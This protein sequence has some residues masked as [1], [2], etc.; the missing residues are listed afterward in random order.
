M[1]HGPL[2]G[3]M[4]WVV[5]ASATASATAGPGRVHADQPAPVARG[6]QYLDCPSSR[7]VDPVTLYVATNGLDTNDGRTPNTPLAT[8]AGAQERIGQLDA[9]PLD[10]DYLVYVRGG[11]YREQTVNWTVTSPNHRVHIASYP[12]ENPVFNGASGKNGSAQS[13]LFNLRVNDGSATNLTVRGLTITNYVHRAIRLY[14]GKGRTGIKCNI[15][16]ENRFVDI[17]GRYGRCCTSRDAAGRCIDDKSPKSEAFLDTPECRQFGARG[18]PCDCTGFGAVTAVGSSKNVFLRNTFIN[19]VNRAGALAGLVHAFYMA[20]GSTQN[21]IEGNYVRNCSGVPFK[22]RDGSND[23]TIRGNY[24]EHAGS[25]AFFL[26][27]RG[28]GEALS[29]GNLLSG[30]IVTFGYPP[31]SGIPLTGGDCAPGDT[32]CFRLDSHQNAARFYQ[33]TQPKE[34]IVTAMTSADVTGDGEPET[35]VALYYPALRFTKVVYSDAASPAE[36]TNVAYTSDFW[37]VEHIVAAD[38][39]GRGM[40]LVT[41]LY[42]ADNGRTQVYHGAYSNGKYDLVGGNKLLDSSASSGWRITAMSAGRSG[43][44]ALPML[45]SAVSRGGSIEIHRG[46]GITQQTKSSKRGVSDGAPIYSSFQ[47]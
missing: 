28:R 26:S 22:F 25:T 27:K 29:T 44:E 7:L 40:H 31:W 21:L 24:A 34:E 16:A 45:Y 46:D 18:D 1:R 36:L 19:V 5:L 32:R 11:E 38:F 23:N 42:N 9:L 8:L 39:G 33:G 47:W 30:N 37:R 12:G 17:G 4:H 10:S 41:S 15:I 2:F 13:L 3:R 14:G 20:H 6:R 43:G 35:F